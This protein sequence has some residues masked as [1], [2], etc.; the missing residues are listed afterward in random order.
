[1]SRTLWPL[2]AL[3]AAAILGGDAAAD[4]RQVYGLIWSLPVA[5]SV[6]SIPELLAPRWKDRQY[7]SPV[8]HVASGLVLI[9]AND[10]VMRAYDLDRRP[11]WSFETGGAISS[12]PVVGERYL[13]FGTDSG[14]MHALDIVSGK[15]AWMHQ[16]DAEVTAPARLFGQDLFFTT[17]LDTLYCVDASSGEYRWHVRRQQPLG[18][19]LYGNAAPTPFLTEGADGR[20]L[21]A[22][23][24]G[25]ADGT[26]AVLDAS[27]GREIWSAGLGKGDAFIDVDADPVVLGEML[28]AAANNGGVTAFNQ[29]DGRVRWHCAVD[30]LTRLASNGNLLVGAGAGLVV[31]IEPTTGQVRWRHAFGKGVASRPV[32]DGSLVLINSDAGPLLVL[33][34]HSGKR[35]QTFG[36]P[37]GMAGEP[38]VDDDLVLAF[39]NGGALYA[40]SSRFRGW[41]QPG[42]YGIDAAIPR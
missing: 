2:A 11:V 28:I 12:V 1:M 35:L 21:R 24:T 8:L 40:L 16:A 17:A 42:R 14:A 19:T 4:P 32:F 9:G 25:Y 41:A 7:A 36:S 33:D 38:A 22:V 13:Y 3:A 6:G 39:S 37:L 15:P 31:G 34:A 27:S 20:V 30:G 5:S 26:V 18:I 10:R 29:L 23:A